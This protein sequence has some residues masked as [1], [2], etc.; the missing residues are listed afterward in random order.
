M[1]SCTRVHMAGHFHASPPS[2][3]CLAR[4]LPFLQVLRDAHHPSAWLALEWLNMALNHLA[5][6]RPALFKHV[7]GIEVGP[8]ELLQ[9][10]AP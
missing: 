9:I 7:Q 1:L 2:S 3:P 6:R 10:G 8:V 4:N 5:Q